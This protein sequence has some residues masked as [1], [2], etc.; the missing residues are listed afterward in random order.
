MRSVL[1]ATK[2]SFDKEIAIVQIVQFMRTDIQPHLAA[3][4]IRDRKHHIPLF[5]S[6]LAFFK[7][8]S[9]RD[10]SVAD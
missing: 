6:G 1:T 2:P 3:A 10:T 9:I 8:R 4:I 5:H 7:S